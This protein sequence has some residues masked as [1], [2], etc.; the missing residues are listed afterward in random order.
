MENKNNHTKTSH[1]A[2]Q[3]LRKR[4]T[5]EA[6]R[7]TQRIKN[8]NTINLSTLCPASTSKAEASGFV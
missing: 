3:I 1:T 5:A 7:R 4:D 8:K 6:V 2:M